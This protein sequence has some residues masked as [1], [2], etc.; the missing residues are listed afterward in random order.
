MRISIKNKLEEKGITRYELAK[1]IDITYPTIDNIYK[2]RGTSIKFEI[3]ESICRELDCTPNDILTSDEEPVKTRLAINTLSEEIASMLPLPTL[4]S[5]KNDRVGKEETS[6]R[7]KHIRNYHL[8][9]QELLELR[10]KLNEKG[11]TK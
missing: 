3:L 7:M 5:S 2:E 9:E 8:K 6:N 11:D 10:K 1:R 4:S